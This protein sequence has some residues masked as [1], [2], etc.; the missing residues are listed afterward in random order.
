MWESG[1]SVSIG[2][3]LMYG[4][5]AAAIGMLAV[6]WILYV[7]EIQNVGLGLSA[8]A[9]ALTVMRDNQRTRRMLARP[10]ENLRSMR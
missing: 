8:L 1:F 5:W 4:L 2:C 3:A 10:G 7:V 9:A 6:G